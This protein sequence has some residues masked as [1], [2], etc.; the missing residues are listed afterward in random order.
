MW[1]MSR[2]CLCLLAP[3]CHADKGSD[4]GLALPGDWYAVDLHVHSNVGSNDTAP[5]STVEAIAEVARDRGL[6]LVVI[7]DHSN[8]AGSMDCASGDVED[9]PNQGPEFPAQAAARAA[10]GDGL[11]L[12]TGVEISPVASLDSLTEPRGHIG[13]IP[14]PADSLDGVTRPVIDRPVGEVDGGTGVAWCQDNGG[15][16]IL[17]HPVTLVGGLAYDWTNDDYAAIEVFNGSARFDEGDVRSLDAWM[18]DWVAGREMVPVGGSDCHEPET[19]SPP[20]ELLDQSLGFPTTWVRSDSDDPDALLGALV[21]GYVSVSDPRTQ[22]RMLIDDGVTVVG[23]G[24]RLETGTDVVQVRL[25]ATL[26]AGVASL[27][28]VEIA[29]DTCPTDTRF[30]DGEPPVAEPVIH[31]SESLEV[32]VP[33]EAMVSVSVGT[34]RVLFARVWPDHDVVVSGDGVAIT[35]AV[36]LLEAP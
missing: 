20:P 8:S 27:Q 36:R 2:F 17:N 28:L 19:T 30:V 6:A 21:A 14:H 34:G 5:D 35:N 7:T 1:T 33:V 13:C 16:P 4:E 25:S 10:S 26:G 31:F 24:Q 9:C 32:G 15:F 29:E 11:S 23:P 12:L 22:L 18:C 3:A